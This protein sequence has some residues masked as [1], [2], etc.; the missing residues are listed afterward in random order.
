M[1]TCSRLLLMAMLVLF[2][3][4]R[5]AS[6]QKERPDAHA[7]SEQVTDD[8]A[9][10]YEDDEALDID[11]L[12]ATLSAEDAQGGKWA[13]AYLVA[14]LDQALKD[15]LSGKVPWRATPFW[16]SSGEN[17]ARELRESIARRLSGAEPPPA[18]LPICQWLLDSAKLPSIQDEA[19]DA[20]VKIKGQESRELIVEI[21]STGHP[22]NEVLRKCITALK[23]RGIKVSTAVIAKLCQHHVRSVRET[24]LAH[25]QSMG[26]TE[27]PKFDPEKAM[28]SAPVKAIMKEVALLM[29]DVPPAQAE[30]VVVKTVARRGRDKREYETRGGS[31]MSVR[32]R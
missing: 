13:A 19:A 27:V 8:L 7:L 2:P 21:V 30:F 10:Y 23:D 29:V 28:Q 1:H 15:E 20:L 25:A 6:A 16:G 24:A 17:P 5:L 32:P 4:A 18:A 31:V 9:R 22:N 14:L 11:M 12:F 3:A 26:I